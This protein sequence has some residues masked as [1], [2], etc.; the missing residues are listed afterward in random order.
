MVKKK[1]KSNNSRK[2]ASKQRSTPADSPHSRRA[3][4]RSR[5]SQRAHG[6]G[7][8]ELFPIVGIGA[9]AGGLAALK[10]FFAH[11][12]ED[13][14]IAF[15]VVVHLSP[16]HKSHLTELLQPHVK[17]P[18]QQVMKTVPLEPNHV[19]VIPPNANLDSIDTHLR[20]TE[21][22]KPRQQRAP[23]DHFFRT[24]AETHDG[25]AIG[26]ILSGT[27]SDGTLGL[28]EIKQQRGLT[29]VQDPTEAE[30]GGMP[31]SAV[32]SGTVSAVLPL[33]EIAP[34]IAS[35]SRTRPKLSEPS[36]AD[37]GDE[38][39]N[40]SLRSTKDELQTVL[41]ENQRKVEEPAQLS[42][43]VQNLLSATGIATL[44]LDRELRIMR[45]TPKVNELLNVRILDRGRPLSDLTYRLS[46]DTLLEDAHQVLERLV[47]I[48]REVQDESGRWFLTR[49]IPY[50]SADDR[51]EGVVLTFVDIS[52]HKKTEQELSKAKIYAESIVETLHEPLLVL[53]PNLTVK[54]VNRAFYQQFQVSEVNTVGRRIYE[55]GNG[56]W[57][58]PALRELLED[59]LP[60][61][62][63][64]ND[65]EVRH[66]FEDIGERIMLVNARR[67][68]HVQLILLG[69]RDITDRKRSEEALRSSEQRLQRM[70]NIDG[71]GQLIFSDEGTLLDANNYVLNML[72]YSREELESGALHWRHMT[73]ATYVAV[74]EEQMQKLAATGCIGP[75][76]KEYIRKDG[77]RAWMVFAGASLGDGTIAEFCIDTSD[78]K[79]T[80]VALREREEELRKLTAELDDRVQERT[81]DLEESQRMLQEQAEIAGNRATQ[82]E[83]LA[84][85][86]TSAE[87]RERR[88][89]ADV[90]HDHIQQELVAV[91]MQIDDLRDSLTG[92][93]PRRQLANVRCLV[94]DTIDKVRSLSV[95]LVPPLLHDQGLAAALEWL[96]GQMGET[97]RLNVDVQ[98]DNAIQIDD[99][100][101]RDLLY[102]AAR[103]LLLNVV[104]HAGTRL[105]NVELI[106]EES[107]IV[108]KVSDQGSGFDPEHAVG[109]SSS[110]GLFHV[111]E[112]VRSTGGEMQIDSRPGAG[113]TVPIKVNE[114]F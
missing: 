75:Y 81:R 46:Y 76:E 109:Q 94:D 38:G 98:A 103:E 17:M 9:S 28:R 63:I 52:T 93:P 2:G 58:I 22:E 62:N 79:R 74:S 1:R 112:R 27:G 68:D 50:R 39:P 11:V 84:S 83:R 44:F 30:Y 5:R 107:S 32:A 51:I 69:I 95:E 36:D 25:A 91:Q 77:S 41:H 33:A 86:L 100:S 15:V 49:V 70:F 12:P 45:F 72:G 43:D 114:S 29:V 73:P 99:E 66:D 40:E 23:I 96:G 6:P 80:E 65:F 113:T 48:E 21:M 34:F 67:L 8:S 97:H 110:Y 90:L 82:L 20:L 55:L 102:Q 71:V 61:N 10:Q 3:V 85:Q 24:L 78:Q 89:L 35:F 4:A 111:W 106:N 47:P 42:D 16:E 88:R 14:G 59:V 92:D 56:Q 26:V 108:M 104:K 31:A 13:S 19:Y 18:V 60:E 105:A 87:Q 53:N 37:E 54:S 57:D 101:H 7:K 64:F